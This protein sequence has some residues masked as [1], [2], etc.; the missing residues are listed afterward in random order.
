MKKT[1]IQL[2]ID[3]WNKELQQPLGVLEDH[4]SYHTEDIK[5][6]TRKVLELNKR[7]DQATELLE[8]ERGQIEEAFNESRKTHPMIGF[9]HETFDKYYK[10]TYK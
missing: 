5:E 6:A 10:D 9:K 2:L 4:R 8:T 3:K 7:I 1:A